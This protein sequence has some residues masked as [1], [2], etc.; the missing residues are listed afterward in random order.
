[1]TKRAVLS[2][3]KAL[4]ICSDVAT[5]APERKEGRGRAAALATSTRSRG[6]HAGQL[7]ASVEYQRD[8]GT[9]AA[10]DDNREVACLPKADDFR[11]HQ[12]PLGAMMQTGLPSSQE[13]L[14]Q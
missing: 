13:A 8:V 3:C 11:P 7:G 4:G 10:T 2:D 6:F 1:M 9:L 12:S 14:H 5:P